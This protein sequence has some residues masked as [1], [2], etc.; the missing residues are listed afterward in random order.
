M[1]IKELIE[2]LKQLSDEAQE[3]EVVLYFPLLQEH[4]RVS[5]VEVAAYDDNLDKGDPFLRLT[6]YVF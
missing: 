5:M 4:F 2:D 3:K 6:T 1:T